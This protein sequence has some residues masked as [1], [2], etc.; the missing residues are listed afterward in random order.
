MKITDERQ[1][2]GQIT[3]KVENNDEFSTFGGEYW[4][5]DDHFEDYGL[6]CGDV[7]F[8]GLSAGQ[9]KSLGLEII[10]HLLINGHSFEI[11]PDHNGEYLR[12][13]P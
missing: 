4:I 2:H 13:K 6:D 10:N 12:G 7:A 11:V 9:Y 8:F 3:C 5:E 1:E